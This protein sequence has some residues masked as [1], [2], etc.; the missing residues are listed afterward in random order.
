[1]AEHAARIR[2][3]RHARPH[4]RVRVPEL[5]DNAIG[6]EAVA[7]AEYLEKAPGRIERV[8][9]ASE[10]TRGQLCRHDAVLRRTPHMQR[11]RHR[12]E[13]HTDARAML[14]AMAS[15][16]AILSASRRMSFAAAAAA[17]NVPTVPD[18]WNPF[19]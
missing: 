5:A 12:P 8:L 7:V 13:I 4:D 18:E 19:L 17:P 16:W 15:A 3:D 9:A 14:A 2:L 10:A 6:V 1:M 11:F